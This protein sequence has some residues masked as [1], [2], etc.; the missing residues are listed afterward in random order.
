MALIPNNK[1]F[2]VTSALNTGM[3]VVSAED[4]LEQTI[5]GLKTLRKIV[6]DAIV[7]LAD[8]SSN[9][10]EEEKFKEITEWVDFIADF[11]TDADVNM[12]AKNHKKSEAECVLLL[13]TLLLL[14]QEP[15]MMKLM[16]SVDRIFKFSGRTDLLNSFNI[17]EHNQWGKYVFKKRIPTWLTDSRKV[18]ATD[19]LITRMYS[20][21]PSLIDDYMQVLQRNIGSI[22]QMRVDTEHA[23]FLNI[24]KDLLV[25]LDTIHCIGTVA[26]TGTTEIY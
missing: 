16:H 4:R 11:S 3:G 15:T 20:L 24:N 14:K 26:T 5:N 12:F 2:I 8:G 23:H 6:P 17:H 1:L 25:E 7:I 19:L 13:K 22:M 21:C 18:H 9:K 10:V